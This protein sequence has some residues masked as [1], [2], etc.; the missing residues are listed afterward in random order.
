MRYI[1]EI[2]MFGV[3]P[4]PACCIEAGGQ[5]ISRI[6]YADLYRVYR[7]TYGAGDGSTTFNVP[8]LR[9]RVAAG[10][11]TMG[12]DTEARLLNDDPQEVGVDGGAI[13]NTGGQRRHKLDAGDTSFE[14]PDLQCPTVEVQSGSGQAVV[15]AGSYSATSAGFHNN[16]QPTIIIP[17]VIYTGVPD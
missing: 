6:K 11:N 17:F 12:G 2:I 3:L 10:P 14:V 8:D 4:P 13:G 15:E 1:G 16:V 7:D 5:A 9:G